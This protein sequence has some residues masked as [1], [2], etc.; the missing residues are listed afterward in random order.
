M[1]RCLLTAISNI[2]LYPPESTAI[3]YSIQHLYQALKGFFSR[4]PVLTLARVG[5]SLLVNGQKIDTADFKTMADGFLNLLES[6]KLR[7][8]SL[9]K[10]ITVRE[11]V[12]FISVIGHSPVDE[13]DSGFWRRLARDQQLYGILFDQ[14]LYGIMQ[15]RVGTGVTTGQLESGED[16]LAEG[17]DLEPGEVI[18]QTATEIAPISVGPQSVEGP[19]AGS[20]RARDDAVH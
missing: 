10:E 12:A 8:L 11:L 1:L 2:K 20:F 17:G 15:E 6:I 3:T 14:R 7:S 4:R 5:E 9:L 19:G 13:F 18:P 16:S